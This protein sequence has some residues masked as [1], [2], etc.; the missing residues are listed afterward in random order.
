MTDALS[1]F[2]VVLLGV[3]LIVSAGELQH[4]GMMIVGGVGALIGVIGM[5][6][7]FD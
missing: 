7:T 1:W 2:G 3:T 6:R 5:V 4:G